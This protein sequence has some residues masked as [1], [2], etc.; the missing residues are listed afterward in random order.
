MLKQ[1]LNESG[2]NYTQHFNNKIYIQ[3]E[4]CLN[5]SSL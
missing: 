1:H 2:K 5:M 4:I 3:L